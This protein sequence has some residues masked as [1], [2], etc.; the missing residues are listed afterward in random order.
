MDEL[1]LSALTKL[2]VSKTYACDTGSHAGKVRVF[3]NGYLDPA[4]LR[5]LRIAMRGQ[6]AAPAAKES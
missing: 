4:E 3:V 5:A 2:V 6:S 1:L